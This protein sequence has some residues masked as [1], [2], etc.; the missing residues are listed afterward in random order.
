MS[1]WAGTGTETAGPPGKPGT[2]GHHPSEDVARRSWAC[3]RCTA[4]ALRR[5]GCAIDCFCQQ[6]LELSKGTGCC[7]GRDG[8]HVGTREQRELCDHCSELA[9]QTV[10][11][12]RRADSAPDGE[13]DLRWVV[14][15]TWE[16][17]DRKGSRPATPASLAQLHERRSV[18][19]APGRGHQ[20]LVSGRQA[21]AAL[22]TAVGD[23]RLAGASGHAVPEAMTLGPL[24][25]VW[26]ERSLHARLSGLGAPVRRPQP[27]R[28]HPE[29]RSPGHFQPVGVR[30]RAID[31]P[32]ARCYRA[33][34]NRRRSSIRFVA[35]LPPARSCVD[36]GGG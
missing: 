20:A 9:P 25:G 28:E 6:G 35:D 22:A 21:Q 32:E 36:A 17:G 33:R 7:G 27:S 34:P 8:D 16:P 29:R 3:V 24:T 11:H 15:V 18:A 31:R 1:S 5:S 10:P 12:H 4:T 13:A 26:L 23:D 14:C 30:R 19:D 2:G